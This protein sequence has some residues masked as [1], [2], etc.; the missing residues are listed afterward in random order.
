MFELFIDRID[1]GQIHPSILNS[2][3]IFQMKN[4]VIIMG[5]L[6]IKMCTHAHMHIQINIYTHTYNEGESN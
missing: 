3:V 1:N 2:N 4:N 6:L 5:R